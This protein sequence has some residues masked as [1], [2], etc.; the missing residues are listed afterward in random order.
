MCRLAD[1][2][3]LLRFPRKVYP[4]RYIFGES[5]CPNFRRP[6]RL[7]DV[8]LSWLILVPFAVATRLSRTDAPH[9]SQAYDEHRPSLRPATTK[10]SK[11]GTTFRK[12]ASKPLRDT[13]LTSP[14]PYIPLVVTD[15]SLRSHQNLAREYRPT[16]RA[17]STTGCRA[18]V[19]LRTV[20]G[21]ERGGGRIRQWC[22]RRPHTRSGRA[23]VLDGPFWQTRLY[24]R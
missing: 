4:Y 16:W 17:H 19:L 8:I 24:P 21:D 9:P 14:S 6:L 22:C 11:S 5:C 13:H 2:C 1:G 18:C 12:V 23:V 20:P 15:H 3:L 7:Q 10:S